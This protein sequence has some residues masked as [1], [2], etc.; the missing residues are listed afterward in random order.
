VCRPDERDLIHAEE[1]LAFDPPDITSSQFWESLAYF[2]ENGRSEGLTFLHTTLND[3]CSLTMGLITLMY[4]R[5][6]VSR[7]MA[8]GEVQEHGGFGP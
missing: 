2:I 1:E 5:I 6:E 4:Q 3:G 7:D 8:F